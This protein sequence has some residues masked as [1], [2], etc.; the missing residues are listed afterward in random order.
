MCQAHLKKHRTSLACLVGTVAFCWPL[1][2]L[3]MHPVQLEVNPQRRQEALLLAVPAILSA[4]TP[5]VSVRR[6]NAPLESSILLHDRGRSDFWDFGILCRCSLL[7]VKL[8]AILNLAMEMSFFNGASNSAPLINEP[9]PQLGALRQEDGA[10]YKAAACR[11]APV[12]STSS[13]RSWLRSILAQRLYKG[14][15]LKG[16]EQSLR[17]LSC[18]N[19]TPVEMIQL[20]SLHSKPDGSGTGHWS[21]AALARDLLNYTT[22]AMPHACKQMQPTTIGPRLQK[23]MH[24]I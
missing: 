24:L 20:E 10:G 18:S 6:Q 17:L 1:A 16:L 23:L 21:D 12:R 14:L 4:S 9:A 15:A 22:M 7:E 19:L 11:S 2:I 13:E 5:D 8:E 3:D